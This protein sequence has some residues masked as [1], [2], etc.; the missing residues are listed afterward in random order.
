[1]ARSTTPEADGSNLAVGL[2]SVALFLAV[3]QAAAFH[4]ADSMVAPSPVEVAGIF[5]TELMSGRLWYHLSATL[6]RVLTAFV[7]AMSI[8]CAIG[9]A[10]GRNRTF[11]A[12]ANPWLIIMLNLPAL[13]TIV[14]CYLWIGLNEVAAVTAVAINK[15]PMIAVMMREGARALDPALDDMAKVFR[16]N[17]LSAWQNVIVPQL[18]PYFA[19]SARSGVALIWKIVLVV[20]FL[21]RSNG[22]GFQI[23]LYFQLFEV[24][25]ILAYAL[26]FVAVML[27]VEYLLVQPWERSATR[28]RLN[29]G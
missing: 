11:D 4:A 19:A 7:V 2:V 24:G 16:M 5:W 20:E 27:A 21:G 15:I 25:Y 13:V 12:W 28:W 17:R 22:I 26:S 9:I 18:A 29:E 10:A 14:L 8:G 6:A 23:H 1:M 3:W